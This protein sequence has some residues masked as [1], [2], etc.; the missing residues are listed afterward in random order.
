MWI[1]IIFAPN[2]SFMS[3]NVSKELLNIY[4]KVINVKHCPWCGS[5]EFVKHGKYK[6]TVRYKCKNCKKTFLPS[7]GT[8]LHYIHKKDLFLSYANFIQREGMVSLKKM[9][10]RFEIAPLTAFDW[11]HK[12]LMS[13][14]LND[15]NFLGEIFMQDLWFLFNQKGRKGI[16]NS[17]KTGNDPIFLCDDNFKTRILSVKDNVR[18]EMKLSNVGSLEKQHFQRLF[19]KKMK[20]IKAI[21]CP[22][23]ECFK[24]FS[25][26]RNT[27]FINFESKINNSK[28]RTFKIQN[29]MFKTWINKRLKGV[30]TKYI[31]MY[32]NYFLGFITQSFEPFTK[33][34][35]IQKNIWPFYTLVEEF[36]ADFVTR[37]TSLEYAF[38]TKRKWKT[39]KL[40]YL[41]E[42]QFRY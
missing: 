12:I 38:P 28:I 11:R 34:Y 29:Q 15:K 36:Y 22:D 39:S 37:Y 35:L 18:G 2:I 40:Y 6:F 32:C 19:A 17:R 10:K 14:P 33:K 27:N 16:P 13:I 5:L 26:N 42:W 9:C 20:K 7:T 30:A 31:A 25:T 3:N 41:K 21:T 4:Q 23:M 8:S 24:K 1:F